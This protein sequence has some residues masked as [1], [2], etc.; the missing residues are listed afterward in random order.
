MS[1]GGFR[2]IA[3]GFKQV[4]DIEV[5]KYLQGERDIFEKDIT[6]L[7]IVAFENKLKSDTRSTIDKLVVSDI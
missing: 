7:G 4:E 1:L 3:Y 2:T 6:A 5:A